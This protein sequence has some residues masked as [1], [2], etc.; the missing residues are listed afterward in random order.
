MSVK[1]NITVI[2]LTG[3]SGAG[4]TTVCEVFR[5]N[6]FD[7]IDCDLICRKIVQK[8]KPCLSE[9]AFKFGSEVITPQGELN[10]SRLGKII[11]SDKTKRSILN[12]IMYP[13]VS[14]IVIKNIL[15]AKNNHVVLD[16]PTLFESGIDDICNTI[17]C[18]TAEKKSLIQR[19]I[20][21][22]RISSEAAENRLN[23]QN[24]PE[25]YINKSNY[26]IFNNGTEEEL[27]NSAL[28]TINTIRKVK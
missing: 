10:R 26:A 1:D 16:A 5:T 4:K 22:D 24:P 20:E 3:M 9:I 12:G 19:I 14:Y 13:Y 23:S 25:F 28:K 21:R 8:G 15:S 6:G 17:V 7:I 18:V 2:G 27:V 11:F